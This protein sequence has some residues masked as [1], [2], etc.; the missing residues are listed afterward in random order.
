MI[1]TMIDDV[2]WREGGYVNHPADKGGPTNYGITQA[3]LTVCRG[4][5]VT[6]EDV[7]M[8][9]V[10]EAR[11]I[12]RAR[13]Y[14]DPKIDTLPSRIQPQ[15][16]DMAVNHGPKAAVRMLQ[17]TL[18][19]EGYGPLAQDGAVGPLTR[20]AAETAAGSMGGQLN[21]ALVDMRISFYL[22]I[23]SRNPTQKVFL[24]GWLRRAEEFRE[25]V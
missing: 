1:N 23:V 18:N 10:D 12:Y 8:L 19:A 7:R 9:P 25:E 11:A 13:Y 22:G 6:A 2:L 17:E 20:T 16:F 14:L 24:K 15:L 4:R 5:P 21:N 3:T